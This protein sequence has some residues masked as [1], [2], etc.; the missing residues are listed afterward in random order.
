MECSSKTDTG[1]IEVFEEA[2]RA[3]INGGNKKQRKKSQQI[4]N[5]EKLS[6][7]ISEKQKKSKECIL[8]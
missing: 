1:V 4:T 6:K 7:E 3:G 2:I 8:L 5:H